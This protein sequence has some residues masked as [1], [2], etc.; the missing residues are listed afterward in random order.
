MSEFE[1]KTTTVCELSLKA[2]TTEH[3][4]IPVKEIGVNT[5]W[6]ISVVGWDVE[7]KEEFV[8]DN[9]DSY[10]VIVLRGKKY[11]ATHDAHRNSFKNQESGRLVLTIENNTYKVKKVLYRYTVK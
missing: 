5:V 4:E 9:A 6:E 3:I 2:G 10:S 1:A 7:Y 11:G 8:P